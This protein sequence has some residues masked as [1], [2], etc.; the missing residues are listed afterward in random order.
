LLEAVAA[1]NGVRLLVLLA[2]VIADFVLGDRQQPASEGIAGPVSAEMTDVS[3]DPTEDFLESIGD[4]FRPKALAPTP[5]VNQRP[6]ESD[7]PPS[8]IGGRAP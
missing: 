2:K 1:A 6:V 4:V 7:E 3:R 5:V 8:G